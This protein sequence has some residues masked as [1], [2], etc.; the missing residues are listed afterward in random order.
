MAKNN[1]KNNGTSLSAEEIQKLYGHITE[2]QLKR[3]GYDDLTVETILSHTDEMKPTDYAALAFKVATAE[4]LFSKDK[5]KARVMG[6]VGKPTLCAP[7]TAMTRHGNR[8]W[9]INHTKGYLQLT[10]MPGDKAQ[11][12]AT[13]HNPRTGELM[14]FNESGDLIAYPDKIVNL[15]VFSNEFEDQD[16]LSDLL[17]SILSLQVG[18]YFD[19][20]TRKNKPLYR[21]T[22]LVVL[23]QGDYP[24]LQQ[25]GSLQIS[26]SAI[27]LVDTRLKA[28]QQLKGWGSA[29]AP[30]ITGQVF[31]REIERPEVHLLPAGNDVIS[32]IDEAYTLAAPEGDTRWTGNAALESFAA[33]HGKSLGAILFGDDKDTAEEPTLKKTDSGFVDF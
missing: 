11:V 31:G 8:G 24:K 6:A 3:L 15:R 9:Y 10:F 14:P 2:G 33:S 7:V 26:A 27:T 25:D 32:V 23:F 16:R 1:N 19:K 4:M 13:N 29:P 5:Q 21:S 12:T 20:V 28:V 30:A 18:T 22:D 17:S